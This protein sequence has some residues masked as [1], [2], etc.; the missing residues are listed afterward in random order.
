L[1]RVAIMREFSHADP[2]PTYHLAMSVV[3]CSHRSNGGIE[4]SA[5][6]AISATSVSMS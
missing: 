1:A 2:G 4:N 5:S 3:P 6:S